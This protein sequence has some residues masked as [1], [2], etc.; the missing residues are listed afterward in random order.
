MNDFDNVYWTERASLLIKGLLKESETTQIEAAKI[1]SI[2]Q[3]SL[4]YKIANGSLRLP[5]FLFLADQLSYDL[6]LLDPNGEILV[7]DYDSQ[8]KAMRSQIESLKADIRLLEKKK[9]DEL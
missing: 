3:P 1:L 6:L 8:I 2:K 9:A 7:Y 5:E 4:A